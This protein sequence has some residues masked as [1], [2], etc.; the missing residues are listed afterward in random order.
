MALV[1]DTL[2]ITFDVYTATA[3]LSLVNAD[4]LPVATV[5][6]NNGV[7][8][9]AGVTITN[10]A[11]GKYTLAYALVVADGWRVGDSYSIDVSYAVGGV[12]QGQVPLS[13]QVAG[14]QNAGGVYGLWLPTA[15]LGNAYTGHGGAGGPPHTI[16]GDGTMGYTVWDVNLLEV[17]SYRRTGVYELPAVDAL[18]NPDGGYSIAG[19]I[20][21]PNGS[22]L[23]GWG[24][25]ANAFLTFE[26]LTPSNVTAL[27]SLASLPGAAS[28]GVSAPTTEI[29]WTIYRGAAFERDLTFPG[30]ISQPG[31]LIWVTGKRQASDLD[32]QAIFQLTIGAGLVVTGPQ[33]AHLH[34]PA[35]APGILAI[36][37]DGAQLDVDVKY[38]VSGSDPEIGNVGRARVIR[39]ATHAPLEA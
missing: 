6:R 10:V 17:L 5:R 23:I 26:D 13:G 27:A 21:L 29:D 22:Y 8:A 30:D 18:G 9:G 16:S 38:Q 2:S 35:N 14:Y 39:T 12:S 3:P 34:L 24:L 4:A 31:T 11:T 28:P 37:D 33:T 25:A 32:A 7:V 1:G 36:K 20:T 19:G 15:S